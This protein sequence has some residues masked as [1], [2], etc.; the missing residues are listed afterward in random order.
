MTRTLDVN[1][2]RASKRQ[3]AKVGHRAATNQRGLFD[4][5]RN[6]RGKFPRSWPKDETICY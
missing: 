4:D 1:P 5:F 3:R 2:S 6:P